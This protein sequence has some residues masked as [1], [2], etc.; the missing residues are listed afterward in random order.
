MIRYAKH[1]DAEWIVSLMEANSDTITPFNLEVVKYEIDHKMYIVN[2]DDDTDV[3]CSLIRF[4][5]TDDFIRILLALTE[6]DCRQ[7]GHSRL[8]YQY[9]F[10]KYQKPIRYLVESGSEI[11]KVWTER[12]DRVAKATSRIKTFKSKDR[13]LTEYE[14]VYRGRK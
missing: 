14:A 9:L 2:V 4:V 5:I 12:N 10:A 3:P 1:E 8:L 7:M 11:E 13:D 6:E